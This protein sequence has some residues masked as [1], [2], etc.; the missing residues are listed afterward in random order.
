MMM[1][2]LAV[3]TTVVE[4]TCTQESLLVVASRNSCIPD[5]KHC[6]HN[7][8]NLHQMQNEGTFPQMQLDIDDEPALYSQ[9]HHKDAACNQTSDVN[10]P[11]ASLVN[12]PNVDLNWPNHTEDTA[13]GLSLQVNGQDYN[14]D[15][16]RL[17]M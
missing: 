6:V 5:N 12:N 9:L 11:D 17:D 10:N 1:L 8:Q 3:A 15:V 13:V 7:I 2:P 16:H 14:G 4:G